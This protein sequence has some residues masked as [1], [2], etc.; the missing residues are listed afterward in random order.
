MLKKLPLKSNENG[1]VG[2]P[3][4]ADGRAGRQRR[5]DACGAAGVDDAGVADVCRRFGRGDRRGLGA[6]GRGERAGRRSWSA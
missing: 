4:G 3:G 5:R 1:I 6:R 2:K